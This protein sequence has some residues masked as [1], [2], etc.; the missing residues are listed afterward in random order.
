MKPVGVGNTKVNQLG[1]RFLTGDRVGAGSYRLVARVA[2]LASLLAFAS[3]SGCAS[4]YRF[5]AGSLYRPDVQTIAVPVVESDILRPFMGERLTEAII[6]EIQLRTPYQIAT[7]QNAQSVLRV[8]LT[9][10]VKR[11]VG[12][13]VNDEP[14]DLQFG[15]IV[16]ATWTNRFGEPLSTRPEINLGEHQNFIPEAGQSM[17]T[18]QQDAIDRLARRIVSQLESDW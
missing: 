13:N 17:T 15:L 6:R 8:R 1:G 3:L 7:E 16:T 14:R 10:D 11:V 4:G 9:N 18:V 5:G 2:L 12:E